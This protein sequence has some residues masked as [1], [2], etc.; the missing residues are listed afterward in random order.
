MHV[1]TISKKLEMIGSKMS[2]TLMLLIAASL[3][4]PSV[5]RAQNEQ[6]FPYEANE[7]YNSFNN[8]FL[9]DNSGQYYYGNALDDHSEAYLWGQASDIYI[10]EDYYERTHDPAAYTLSSN[11]LN[12]FISTNGTN[13]TGDS[14]NDD[15]EWSILA[16]IRGYQITGNTTYLTIAENNWNAV[17]SRGWDTTYGGGGI[18]ENM[19]NLSG[20]TADK[21][22]LSNDPFIIAGCWL[23]QATG[24][25]TY[26]TESEADYSW[27]WNNIF[28]HGN[29][30]TS[31]GPPGQ[32]NEGIRFNVGQ[33]NSGSLEYSDNIYNSGTFLEAGNCLDQL[34]GNANYYNDE[35]NDINHIVGEGPVMSINGQ[36]GNPQYQYW[37][38]KGLSDF[39][40][41]NN[42]WPAYYAWLLGNADTCWENQD[43]SGVTEDNWNQANSDSDPAA[44]NASSSVAIWQALAVA[45][46]YKVINQD[47]GLAMDLISGNEANNAAIEQWTPD[48]GDANQQWEIVA[49][50]DGN[51]SIVSS[52]TDF[53]A[54]IYSGSTSE[55]AT[56]VDW[57]YSSGNTSL[58]YKFNSKGTLN[59]YPLYQIQNVNS[60]LVLD[61]YGYGTTN[62]TE[63]DQWAATGNTNQ[64][65]EVAPVVSFGGTYILQ[66]VASTQVLDVTGSSTTAGA[67]VVQNPYSGNNSQ[68]WTFKPDSRGNYE[69]VNVNSGQDLNVVGNSF[70]NSAD[71]CQWPGGNQPSDQ[72]LPA[73]NSNGTYTF[74]NLNSG[75][76]LDNPGASTTSGEQYDQ[77]VS[78]TTAAQQFYLIPKGTVTQGTYTLA[79]ACSTGSRLDV[80]SGGNTNGTNVDIYTANNSAAQNW[81]LTST[82]GAYTLSPK[83]APGLVLDVVAGGGSGSNVDIWT[84]NGGTNQSWTVTAN[85]SGYTLTPGCSTGCRLDVAAA[86]GSGSNV[87]IYTANNTAAQNWSITPN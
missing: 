50:P 1:L 44:L 32:V 37:F 48:A 51:D 84:A 59:G 27:A 65:W 76:A 70:F 14:W 55:G 83:C 71:E 74:Y 13:W 6:F 17:Y 15:L 60:G 41:D 20:S 11:L 54:A 64:N 25:S 66:N 35:L 77:Y 61:D 75:L 38:T 12:R 85:G 87:E 53:G 26:L 52:L 30:T 58:E 39:C 34:T 2:W 18:W 81:T 7:V 19:A 63:I 21:C 40:T 9:V 80:A 68:S 42:D 16:F 47:S 4:H 57:P 56:L 29:T 10:P 73:L 49:T 82:G 22:A 78:N 36:P 43:S 24:T 28:N 45:Q 72:W 86:G 62:G 67:A 5:A 31:L 46:Q 69:I 33:P 3:I 8:D 79:P 23:Y